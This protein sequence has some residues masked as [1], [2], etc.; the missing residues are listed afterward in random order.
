MWLRLDGFHTALI[1]PL[2]TMHQF[3]TLT[4]RGSTFRASEVYRRQ[5]MTST[6]HHRTVRVKIPLIVVDP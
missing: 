3:V 1:C 6:V 5:I 4:A 2:F